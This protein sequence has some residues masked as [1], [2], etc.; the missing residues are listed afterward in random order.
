MHDFQKP[1]Q[2]T[3]EIVNVVWTSFQLQKQ[4]YQP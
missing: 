2:I 3:L 4:K 1:K